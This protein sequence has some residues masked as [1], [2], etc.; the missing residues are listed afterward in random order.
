[1]VESLAEDAQLLNGNKPLPEPIRDAL[2]SDYPD[3]DVTK[4]YLQILADARSGKAGVEVT[5]DAVQETVKNA[6]NYDGVRY[7]HQYA[8]GPRKG[9][10]LWQNSEELLKPTV[11][12]ARASSRTTTFQL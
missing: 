2:K 5:P 6:G 11:P 10:M 9:I 8:E 3:L 4:S 1:M 12:T 7:E